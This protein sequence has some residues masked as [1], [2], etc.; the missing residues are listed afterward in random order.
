MWISV[1]QLKI[2][3]LFLFFISVVML[4]SIFSGHVEVAMV[5]FAILL[6]VVVWN[7]LVGAPWFPADR[8][9]VDKMVEMAR[10]KKSD[11]VYDLGSGDG[12]I[13]IK[14]AGR[15]KR[16]VGIELNSVMVFFSKLLLRINR[17]NDKIEIR[18][19]DIFDA[20]LKDADVVFM[21]LLQRTND[22][23]ERKLKKELKKGARI[24]SH[25][26]KFKNI[27]L[28]KADEKLKVYLYKV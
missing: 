25:M 24:V 16:L 3:L 4:A 26:W 1:A 27:K 19:G 10:L 20:N 12:R 15:A 18:Q 22:R 21:F 9:V 11:V 17:L 5:I 28:V 14:S 13:L 2:L 8:A 6:G 7:T 23:I